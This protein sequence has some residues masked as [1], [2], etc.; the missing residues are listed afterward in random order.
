MKRDV[1]KTSG[2]SV[3]LAGN[4]QPPCSILTS[5]SP[6][7]AEEY[8]AEELRAHLARIIGRSPRVLLN[9]GDS[10][11]TIVLNDPERAV[12]DGVR[13]P[14][15]STEAFH[16]ETRGENVHLLGGGPRGTIYAVY[17]LLESFGC[18][19]YAPNVERIPH[20]PHVTVPPTRL[21]QAPAFEYR[22]N[23]NSDTLDAAWRVRN[24][25][26]SMQLVIPDYMGGQIQYGMWCHT[27]FSLLPIDEF[28]P[29]H[30]EY[31]SMLDGTRRRDANQLCVTN[32]EVTRIVTARLLERIKANPRA[33]IF[34]LS[35]N[36]GPG[37]C[38]CP[39]C[40]AVAASE[41]SQM[42]P[43]LRFVNA[44]AEEVAKV[45]PDK[46]IDTIA[47]QH[48][49]DAPRHVRPRSNVRVRVCP[50]ACCQGHAYGTCDHPESARARRAL[51]AWTRMTD[52]VY[53][54]H[55]STNFA[56]Y[57][58]PMPN[59]KEFPA[60]IR[61]FHKHG[62]KGVFLQGAGDEGGGAE[63][64][65]L[66]GYLAAKLLWN[67]KE[68]EGRLI[69]DFCSAYYGPGVTS[70]L[71]YIKTFQ[72]IVDRDRTLHPSLGE[73]PN[74]R[75][76]AES[77]LARAEKALAPGLKATD[78]KEHI[79]LNLLQCGLDYARVNHG[80]GI[81]AKLGN[82]YKGSATAIDRKRL[83]SL[84]KGIAEAGVRCLSEG[85]SSENR[86]RLLRNRLNRHPVVTLARNGQAVDLVPALGGRILD[87]RVCGRS[88]LASADPDNF[89][90]PSPDGYLEFAGYLTGSLEAYTC[91]LTKAAAMLEARLDNGLRLR[92]KV[93]LCP[94]GLRVETELRNVTKDRL[95]TSW[96]AR[97]LLAL[98]ED[99]TGLEFDDAA[100][101]VSLPWPEIREGFGGLVFEGDRLP[102]QKTITVVAGGYAIRHAITG[103]VFRFT[104]GKAESRRALWLYYCTPALDL[105]PGQVVCLSQTLAVQPQ[106]DGPS[107]REGQ[108]HEP[109]I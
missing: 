38:Q 84:E 51:A 92:R 62:V 35:Q 40:S 83:A 100:G 53:V 93:S 108:E 104:T 46:L 69:R 73:P 60:A 44:V 106:A 59:L 66:R 61:F 17:Q 58:L 41:G 98:P 52:Q 71:T 45:F 7:P 43:V 26:H 19:W 31:F 88:W 50:I 11:P 90:Y 86:L 36:D 68:D 21:T 9:G 82:L 97:W 79:R 70:A 63:L 29:T 13:L 15:L 14:P 75:L 12:R 32:P 24:R 1:W 27:F 67:P 23:F 102:R 77:N 4:G 37:W 25:L 72:D 18:R 55:Y 30:P 95:T 91:R 57:L 8:A 99:K 34:S 49:L 56:H 64:M 28:F 101:R 6:S 85:N 80:T 39:E 76:F 74:S 22:D 96:G 89:D 42:G 2:A 103:D 54:W 33:T 3:V 81:F 109:R 16:I 48:T 5:S 94:G 10:G 105:A 47:Y 20:L 87:Y 107:N 78:G 65:A